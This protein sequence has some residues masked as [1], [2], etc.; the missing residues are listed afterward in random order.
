MAKKNPFRFST[1]FTDNESGLVY[2]GYRYYNPVTG[3]WL[4]RDLIEEDGGINIYALIPNDPL[5]YI[6]SDGRAPFAR[7]RGIARQGVPTKPAASTGPSA[8]KLGWKG[9]VGSDTPNRT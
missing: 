5:N 2:Y 4:T 9:L 6:D 7:F 3:R 8:W 1:K